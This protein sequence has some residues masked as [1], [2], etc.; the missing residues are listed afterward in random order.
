MK[1]LISQELTQGNYFVKV[2]LKEFSED[3]RVITSRI[4]SREGIY[5]SIKDFLGK[6]K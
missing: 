3:D 4:E 6:G 2:M 1:F 5:G